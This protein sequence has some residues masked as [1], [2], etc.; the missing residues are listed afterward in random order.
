ME[1]ATKQKG[2]VRRLKSL[3]RKTLVK[4]TAL[5][6]IKLENVLG[7]TLIKNTGISSSSSGTS[8]LSKLDL[9]PTSRYRGLSCRL[10]DRPARPFTRSA[11]HH[12]HGEEG[13]DLPFLGPRRRPATG[14]RGVWP[15]ASSQGL[16]CR[17]SLLPGQS[18]GPQV[19]SEERLFLS[20]QQ[21][22]H[23]GQCCPRH[24]S[25]VQCL[26]VTP[27]SGLSMTWW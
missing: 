18:H 20:R 11:P 19:W 10:C 21:V 14:V 2:N 9:Q 15:Q 26:Y 17:E 13:G 8:L 6:E 3:K 12:Q 25:A 23:L 1:D 16:G 24:G 22:R 7:V 27:R 4:Q 5:E